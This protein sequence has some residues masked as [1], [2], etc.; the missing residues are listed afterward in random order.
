V[1]LAFAVTL[2]VS[3]F[4]LFLIQPMIAQMIL[5][6]LGGTPAVWNTCMVFFQAALLAGYGYTHNVTSFLTPRRQT[7]VHCV[8]LAM[9]FLLFRLPFSIGDWAPPVDANPIWSVLFILLLTVGVP[10]FVV[11]TSAPLLQRWFGSTG[12]ASAKDPYFLY[13]ASNL[14]SMVALLSYPFFFQGLFELPQMAWIWT[15]CY[16]VMIAL[17]VAC[18]ATVWIA[19]PAVPLMIAE[20]SNDPA[21]PVTQEAARR[22]NQVRPG[23]GRAAPALL[24]PKIALEHVSVERAVTWPR[25]LRWIALAAA[26]TSLMLGVTT[27][28]TTDIAGI[29]LFMIIPLA[30][31][32]LSFVFVFARWPVPW[33][34]GPHQIVLFLQ[35]ICLMALGMVTFASISFPIWVQMVVHLGA[36]FACALACHGELARD[37]P[38]IRHLTEF[39]LWMSVGGVCGGIFNSL[40]AP[41]IFNKVIEYVLVLVLVVFLRPQTHF[42]AWVR[43]K[44][45]PEDDHSMQEYLL[46]CGWA[47]C[48]GLLAMALYKLATSSIWKGDLFLTEVFEQYKRIFNM[49]DTTATSWARWTDLLVVHGIPVAI[50]LCFSGRPARL[51]LAMICLFYVT[52]WGVYRGF[53]STEWY[54]V[55]GRH[56]DIVYENRS[57]FSVQSVRRDRVTVSDRVDEYYVLIHGSID[58]G[59]QLLD[60]ARRDRPISYFW[61]T[62]PIGQVYTQIQQL[63]P[64]PPYAIIGLGIGTM[65]SYSKPGQIVDFYEI[66]PAVLALSEPTD[67][68]DP[69]FW[70]LRDAKS[71][72]VKLN[73]HLGDGRLK[74]QEAPGGLYQ[75]IVVDAF[76]SDAIPVHLLTKEAIQ[77]YLS[78]MREDGIIVFNITNR[79]VRLAPVLADVAKELDLIC[80]QQ[81]DNGDSRNPEHFGSDWVIVFR[82]RSPQKM[83]AQAAALVG[84][85]QGGLLGAPPTATAWPNL[86]STLP[87]TWA[88]EPKAGAAPSK[89]TTLPVLTF[90]DGLPQRLYPRKWVVPEPTGR[91]AWTDSFQDLVRAMAW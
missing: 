33:T 17:V 15:V 51:G 64:R 1:P 52:Y 25:R 22:R 72:G 38:P 16:A 29:P 23:R 5:P 50:C 58:H 18:A 30:L 77:I 37:R 9:P 84:S 59:R 48:L 61:P 87:T 86:A 39:Y 43:G 70:Y 26:P 69:Y 74:I 4:L 31:Y 10:F 57:F 2:F 54:Q 14:G 40:V 75:S 90:P 20:A 55:F 12:H 49:E 88:P 8:I 68:S 36:F 82:K 28:F 41:M 32:L 13:G 63:E 47:V 11:A 91:R 21:P 35:P 46:D 6:R 7:I 65:A 81:S 56:P 27:H 44:E 19:R 73:V 42:L 3:A 45:Q 78:K 62:N 67:G 66:D 24:E 89:I 71:R 34:G 85:L 76:S 79:Y 53:R 80:L 83:A 60:P